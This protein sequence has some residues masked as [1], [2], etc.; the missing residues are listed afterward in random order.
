[1]LLCLSRLKNKVY[2]VGCGSGDVNQ[3]TI[4][5]Y[6][7]IKFS[8]CFIL[9]RLVDDSILKEIPH[10]AE[11]IYVGKKCREHTMCQE[12]IN[13]LILD[14]H[15]AGKT[16]A[17]LKGGDSYIFGRGGE[18]VLFL[19]QNGV[20]SEVISGITAASGVAA[21]IGL[22]LTYRGIAT[23]LLITT[24]HKQDGKFADINWVSL[25]NGSTTLALYMGLTNFSE[26]ADKLLENGMDTSSQ[27]LA[28]EN[29]GIADKQKIAVFELSDKDYARHNLGS[30]VIIFIGK[31]VDFAIEQELVT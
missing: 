9:D 19:K 27:V 3:L 29:G 22:P 5:A 25:V 7:A 16:V 1:L 26:I 12:D 24:G 6:K 31:A 13:Q 10:S 17:R 20:A 8:N 28:V 15:L 18:E 11:K 2:I 30:P 4:A 14:K 23:S 21:S